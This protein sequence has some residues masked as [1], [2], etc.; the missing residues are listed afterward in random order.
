MEQLIEILRVLNG[1]ETHQVDSCKG[2]VV[3]AQFTDGIEGSKP[4]YYHDI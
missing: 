1:K 2:S 4:I 3:V